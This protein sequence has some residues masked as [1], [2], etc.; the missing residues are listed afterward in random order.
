[1]ALDKPS[2]SVTPTEN[3]RRLGIAF[4]AIDAAAANAAAAKAAADAAATQ[5][6]L[7]QVR[8]FAEGL[9]ESKA[10]QAL[11]DA[12]RYETIKPQSRPGDAP[13]AFMLVSD[14][15]QLGGTGDP[16]PETSGILKT[17]F[18]DAGSV[19]RL[20]GAGIVAS[21]TAWPVEP[22]RTY[23]ARYAYQRRAN[24]SDPSNDSVRCLLVWLDQAKIVLSGTP[25]TVVQDDQTLVTGSGRQQV[26]KGFARSAGANLLVAPAGA[27]YVRVVGQ[28]FGVDGVTDIEVLDR[29]DVTEATPP[30]PG[31]VNN[32]SRLGALESLN[33]GPRVNQL[34]AQAGTPNSI[35]FPSKSDAQAGTIPVTVTTVLLLGRV[36]AGDGYEGRFRRISGAAPAGSDTF[37][38]A[39]Q[40]WIRVAPAGEVALLTVQAAAQYLAALPTQP[41]A[42]GTLY[43]NG[44][45]LSINP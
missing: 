37:V 40:T 26:E 8:A 44:Q 38:N 41:T 39:G 13:A 16:R 42:S 19:V 21:R 18:G 11:L 3:Y 43:L 36:E 34:E 9:G 25:F 30:A 5:A 2:T 35:T 20:R 12:R 10:D 45:A 14:L 17:A 27:C 6:D 1:M 28:C 24:P 15:S 22:G 23:A 31:P 7:A 29:V 32:E 33:L 4:D